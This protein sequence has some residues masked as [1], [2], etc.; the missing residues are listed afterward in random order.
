MV[1]TTNH[2]RDFHFDIINHINEVK[3]R[4]AIGAEENEVAILGTFDATT[5]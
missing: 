5:H 4:F 1:F 2:M 3:D